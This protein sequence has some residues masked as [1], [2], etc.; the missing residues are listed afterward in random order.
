MSSV[1]FITQFIEPNAKFSYS[2][3]I[4]YIDREEA[5]EVNEN[6]LDDEIDL[7][8][9]LTNNK[10]NFNLFDDKNSN[11]TEEEKNEKKKIFNAAQDS[12]SNLYRSL[13]TF[14]SDDVKKFGI[15]DSEKNSL[16]EGE[17]INLVRGAMDFLLKRENFL[18]GRWIAKAHLNTK[19]LHIHIGIVEMDVKKEKG[20]GRCYEDK[21]GLLKQRGKFKESTLLLVRRKIIDE[22]MQSE[23]INL[24]INDVLRKEIISPLK[25]KELYLENILKNDFKNLID[26]LPKG[27]WN[28]ADTRF[29]D[30]KNDIDDFTNKV[31]NIYFKDEFDELLLLVDEKQN[32]YENFLGDDTYKDSILTD[33]YKRM[34][35]AL[36]KEARAFKNTEY[37]KSIN[38]GDK[39]IVYKKKGYEKDLLKDSIYSYRKAMKKNIQSMKNQIIHQRLMQK[40][41]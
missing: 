22:L 31:I 29:R 37:I 2:D 11:F 16:N 3:F 32:M 12:D 18:D 27:R 14:K 10:K 17:L 33:F 28:Y 6:F 36:L 30:L 4:D 23:K 7:D 26:K 13:I 8:L 38:R 1:N 5:V 35:N 21:N 25:E 41:R 24:K 34:G 40:Y 19:H 20:V 9:F 39:K 15:Y